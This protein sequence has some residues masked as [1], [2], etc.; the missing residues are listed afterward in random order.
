M[1]KEIPKVY[2]D[3][4][5]QR[6]IKEFKLNAIKLLQSGAKPSLYFTGKLHGIISLVLLDRTCRCLLQPLSN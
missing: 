1:E 4:K 2:V 3:R 5:R 6:Y